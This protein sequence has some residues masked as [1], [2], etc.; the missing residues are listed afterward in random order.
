MKKL[1]LLF[2]MILFLGLTVNAQV[3][4]KGLVGTNFAT[5]HGTDADVSAKAG[6]QFGGG[7]LIGNKFYV[8]PGIQF[9]RS[10]RTITAESTSV[11]F[12]QNLVKIPVYA[13]V[14]VLG[15]EDKPFALRLF[16]GPAVSIP[17]KIKDGNDFFDKDNI[18]NAI[19]AV[20]GGVGLDIFF[21]F[22]E[23]NYEY[24]F[25]DYF[26]DSFNDN[27]KHGAFIINAGV[28]IDF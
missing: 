14:H 23:A 2:S 16:A 6:Y 21:L 15:A 8:E 7:V 11:D 25:N 22:I 5:F 17:G 20:D 18:N 28:H 1:T 13:G 27:G 24:S 4:L 9:V 26:V 19:W 12:S 3:E 10:S